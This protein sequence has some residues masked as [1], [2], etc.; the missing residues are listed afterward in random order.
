MKTCTITLLSIILF[1]AG[2]SSTTDDKPQKMLPGWEASSPPEIKG[3]DRDAI[4]AATRKLLNLPASKSMGIMP[5]NS[6]APDE[7]LSYIVEGLKDLHTAGEPAVCV[8]RDVKNIMDAL[9]RALS[10]QPDVRL[11]NMDIVITSPTP[12]DEQFKKWLAQKT[13]RLHYLKVLVQE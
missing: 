10:S 12:P 8:G 6:R 5:M 13:I 11:D 2:C 7:A 1:V 3:F 4:M 9:T